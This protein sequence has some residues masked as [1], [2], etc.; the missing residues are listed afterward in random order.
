MIRVTPTPHLLQPPQPARELLRRPSRTW[1]SVRPRSRLPGLSSLY[2]RA[3]TAS[4][5]TGSQSSMPFSLV[6]GRGMSSSDSTFVSPTR[7]SKQPLRGFSPSGLMV[8]VAEG[9]SSLISASSFVARVLNAFHDLHA[10]MTTHEPDAF[11]A[12]AGAGAAS[13]ALRFFA[14]GMLLLTHGN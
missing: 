3:L 12:A 5:A 2:L 13:S 10:S 4:L 11:L 14:G 6:K 1:V 7:T 9:C 8:T